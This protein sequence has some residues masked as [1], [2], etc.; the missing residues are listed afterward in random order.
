MNEAEAVPLTGPGNGTIAG[1]TVSSTDVGSSTAGVYTT[2]VRS[3]DDKYHRLVLDANNR[4]LEF[5]LLQYVNPTAMLP[6]GQTYLG[7]G[8]H[9]VINLHWAW[10]KS[11]AFGP[12]A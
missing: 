10:K 5:T 12:T 3:K 7:A 11:S 6:V 1:T 2:T 9:R 8:N 4:K